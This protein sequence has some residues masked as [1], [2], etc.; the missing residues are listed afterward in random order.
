MPTAAK[1]SV[2]LTLIL[3]TI[4][5]SVIE[6]IGSETPEINAGMANLFMFLKLMVLLKVLV[7]NS[8]KD[9]YFA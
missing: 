2:A 3:P 6:S 7:R 4:A 8:K 5:V 1:D 9:A